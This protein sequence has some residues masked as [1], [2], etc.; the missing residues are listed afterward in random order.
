MPGP[1]R[2]G[3]RPRSLPQTLLRRHALVVLVCA[4]K[5]VH[6]QGDVAQSALGQR[7]LVAP[8]VLEDV[9]RLIVQDER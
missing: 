2:G 8:D 3:A 5:R 7:A 9:L 1:A 6:V 4:H